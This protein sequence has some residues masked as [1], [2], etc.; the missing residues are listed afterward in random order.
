MIGNMVA[1]LAALFIAVLAMLTLPQ[2][3]NGTSIAHHLPTSNSTHPLLVRG[4]CLHSVWRTDPGAALPGKCVGNNK[5]TEISDL[6]E[7]EVSNWAD[8]RALCCNLEQKCTTWQYQNSTKSCYIHIRP[9]RRGPEGADTP[10][11]CDPFPTHKWN[12][13]HL[14]PPSGSGSEKKCATL[15][16]IPTQCFAF[17]PERLRDE[18]TKEV[19]TKTGGKRLNTQECED[20]CCAD[21]ECDSYQEYPGRGCYYGKSTCVYEEVESAYEGGRKC[22]PGFCGGKEYEQEI[23]S[24]VSPPAL[25]KL[26]TLVKWLKDNP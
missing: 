23:L 10:L 6:K 26:N 11:Y 21:P 22:L 12:G 25:N 9:F 4:K 24:S 3:T 17:G 2:L 14:G 19:S 15:W 5:H 20:A 16:E 1:L 18:K 13:K 8:C 7:I